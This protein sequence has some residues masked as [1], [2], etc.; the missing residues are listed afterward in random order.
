VRNVC[1]WHLADFDAG[2]EELYEPPD[3]WLLFPIGNIISCGLTGA[4]PP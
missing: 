3:L 1:I 4:L 2:S